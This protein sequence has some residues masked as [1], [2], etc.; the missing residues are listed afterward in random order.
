METILGNSLEKH[1]SG[2][3]LGKLVRETTLENSCAK[4]CLKTIL[5]NILG[6]YLG[7]LPWGSNHKDPKDKIFPGD[8]KIRPPAAKDKKYNP[9]GVFFSSKWHDRRIA[10]ARTTEPKRF[11]GSGGCWLALS[12]PNLRLN[13]NIFSNCYETN[14]N[15]ATIVFLVVVI[16]L[17]RII[18]VGIFV[19]RLWQRIANNNMHK[20]IDSFINTNPKFLYFLC[21]SKRK[22]C[23]ATARFLV[24]F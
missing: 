18:V 12:P 14:E 9:H 8:K 10:H 22:E 5:E 4:L 23:L 20:T 13:Q 3:D 2:N 16:R 7:E 17:Q 24:V 6:N 15:H 11:P 21:A 1:I 19:F